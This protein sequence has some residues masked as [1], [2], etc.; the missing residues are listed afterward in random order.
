MWSVRTTGLSDMGLLTSPSTT[1]ATEPHNTAWGSAAALLGQWK[2]SREE[3]KGPGKSIAGS[4]EIKALS[5]SL[6]L[7]NRHVHIHVSGVHV[8][9]CT[10]YTC[11]ACTHAFGQHLVHVYIFTHFCKCVQ[12]QVLYLLDMYVGNIPHCFLLISY[13]LGLLTPAMWGEDP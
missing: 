5:G 12:A 3:L 7:C 1:L 9:K 13:L 8:Y 2:D 4:W 10:K 6:C 11:D